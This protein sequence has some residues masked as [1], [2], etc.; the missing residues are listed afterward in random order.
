MTPSKIKLNKQEGSLSL[1]YSDASHFTLTGE[2][3]R[4]H[5]PSAEVRGHGKG[6]EVLQFGKKDVKVA[7]LEPSGNYAI[8]ITFDDNHDSGIYS[9]DYLYDLAINH[10][11][12]WGKYTEA[13][14]KAG[15][16]REA[17]VQVVQL[18]D[19]KQL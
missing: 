2:Y 9:W 5:S 11:Q 16:H 8:Q 17:N 7:N 10:S 6:Q 13:L 4:V 14:Q 18:V 15:K 19:P 12:Y 1:V 3:L